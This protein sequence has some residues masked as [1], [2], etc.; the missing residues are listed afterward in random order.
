VPSSVRTIRADAS[1]GRWPALDTPAL[2]GPD[3]VRVVRL[4]L[5][6]PPPTADWDTL[7]AAEWER[8]A[9]FVFPLHRD[10]FVAARAGLRRVLGRCLGR[11]PEDLVFAYSDRGRPRLAPPLGLDFN[12]AHSGDVALL[13]LGTCT[14]GVDVEMMRDMPNVL[15]IARRFFAPAEVAA[16]IR[17]DGEARRRGFFHAWTRKEALIKAAGVGLAALGDTEVALDAQAN[18]TVFSAPGGVEGWR[19][20]HLEPCAG[21]V[22]AL[23]VRGAN[24]NVRV[25]TWSE[26]RPS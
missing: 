21:Y 1:D 20:F 26:R 10:R 3:E 15:T 22:G 14:V 25:T 18:P 9:R 24:E 23:A 2:P 16:L 8:A 11:A 7:S 4:F 12:L 19:L 13:A 5:D 17:L 6:E